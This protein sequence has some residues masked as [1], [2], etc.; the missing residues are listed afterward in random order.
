MTQDA[1]INELKSL[2]PNIKFEPG[3]SDYWSSI[4]NTVYYTNIS[5]SKDNISTVLHET[6]HGIL[7]HKKYKSD[8]ELIL[9][10]IAAWDH[11]KLLATDMGTDID[12]DHI[13]NCLDSYRDWQYK[14]SLCP[15][16]NLGGV[17][18]SP[19]QYSCHFCRN[20]WRVSAARF[21]RPYR[22]NSEN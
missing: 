9:M 2:H 22:M 6:S 13:Q 10:E 19:S 17:Q 5:E 18:I 4:D 1:I 8:F 15:R 20:I 11:A 12:E 14:R 3:D 7:K 16:C 21:C